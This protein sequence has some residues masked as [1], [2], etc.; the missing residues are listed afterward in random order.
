MCPYGFR[1][2]A[3]HLCGLI[4]SV[5]KQPKFIVLQ[6]LKFKFPL[7]QWILLITC[8]DVTECVLMND[9]R[10]FN[11][12]LSLAVWNENLPEIL[13]PSDMVV[14]T[15]ELKVGMFKRENGQR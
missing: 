15:K 7:Q 1:S 3:V 12:F 6:V 13:R 4:C 2:H 8:G 11:S 9:V 14:G 5:K 10:E